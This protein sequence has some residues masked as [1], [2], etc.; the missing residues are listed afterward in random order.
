MSEESREAFEHEMAKRGWKVDCILERTSS[1]SADGN[2]TSFTNSVLKYTHVRVREAWELWQ[3]A[4]ANPRDAVGE[5]IEG[6]NIH[7]WRDEYFRRHK[8]AADLCERALM[9]EHRVK[10]LE[11][12]LREAWPYVRDHEGL[13]QHKIKDALTNNKTERE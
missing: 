9:A 11:E 12:A 2:V 10:K 6:L 3:A 8:D 13:I 7:E 4:R 5:L 1:T